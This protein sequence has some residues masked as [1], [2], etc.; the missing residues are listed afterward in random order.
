MASEFL[1][2]AERV[3]GQTQRPMTVKEIVSLAIGEGWFSDKRAGKTPYQ[4][5]K[6]KLSVNIRRLGDESIFVRTAPGRFALRS[7]IEGAAEVYHARRHQKPT[8]QERVLVIPTKD[9]SAIANFQGITNRWKAA[10]RR[11]LRREKCKYLD[12][13][14][15]EGDDTYKQFLTYVVI[16]RRGRILCYRRGSYSNVES[17][18]RGS[19][20]IGFGGHVSESDSRPL[21]PSEDLGVTDCVI[22][23]LNEELELPQR[24]KRRLERGVGIQCIGALN[25]DSSSV[26]RRHFAFVFRYEVS[27][28]PS[29]RKP[30]RGEKSITQLRWLNSTGRRI[31]IS[32][33]E[34][35]SQL[36]LRKF[37]MGHVTTEQSYKIVRRQ[38]LIPPHLLCLV[39]EVGSGKSKTT[40]ILRDEYGYEEINT[41]R[42][43]A[44]LLGVPPV[45]TTPREQFQMVAWEFICSPTGPARLA[46]AILTNASRVSSGRVLVDGIRQTAT[47]AQLRLQAGKQRI[48]VL[49]VFTPPD[50]AFGFYRDR[51]KEDISF[52]EY[53]AIR[54]AQVEREVPGMIKD[55]DGVLYNWTGQAFHVAT[56]RSMF[57]DLQIDKA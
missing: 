27:S 42:L 9:F 33:F 45:P 15:A 52:D 21:F 44:D 18:L 38:P 19:H 11:L 30:R 22:R 17:Y 43:V 48:G 56:I 35:W 54:N 26:G 34:Y 1:I 24:D 31:P 55:A 53:L 51:E 2:V 40:Q 36:V 50:M 7:Y 20:C 4:T 3:L 41:G 12:R 32:D 28:D 16:T 13:M 57:S 46:E 5:L 39:G 14:T 37:F 10:R 47:L 6:S 25:D 29:W 49:Y 8:S 23:E